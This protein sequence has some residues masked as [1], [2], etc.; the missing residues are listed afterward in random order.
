MYQYFNRDLSWIDF[1][2][3][4]LEEGVRQDAPL[5]ERFKFLSIV[6]SNFDEFF[7]V[8][9]AA[10]KT[11]KSA[12]VPST[13]PSGLEPA[14]ILKKSAEKIRSILHRLYDSLENDLFPVF[15]KAGLELTRLAD[16]SD[17]DAELLESLFVNEI[18]PLLTPLRLEDEPSIESKCVYAAFLLQ[19]ENGKG[20]TVA[21]VK[22][23]PVMER[24]V[25]IP[26]KEKRRFTL[27]EDMV[28]R[29]GRYLYPGFHVKERLLFKINRDAD[30]SVDEKRDE[31]FIEAMTEVIEDRETSTAVCMFFSPDSER[32][33]KKIASFLKLEDEDL[34]EVSGPLQLGDLFQLTN[35]PGF[36]FFKE[37]TWKI[38]PHPAFADPGASIWDVIKASD[39]LIH[40]PYQSFEPVL[41]FFQSA[42]VDPNVLAVKIAL[43]R[44]SG[45]SPIVK[46][47]EQAA[48]NGKQVT[49]FVELKARFDEERNIS[50]ARRL[51][52]AGV[53]VVYG[54]ANLKVHAKAS[55]VMRREKR[56]VERFVHLSTGN[57]NDK[58]A[59][60]YEDLSFFT[61][62]E[63]IAFD[64]GLLFNML[65]GYSVIQPMRRLIIAPTGLKRELLSLIG[66]ES[67]RSS[68][69]YPGR[70]MAKMNA[71]VDTSVIDALYR[72]SQDGVRIDL[73]VRGVCMLVPGVPALSENIRVVSVVDHFLEHSRVFYF[74]NGGTEEVFLSSADWMPRN[75]ERRVELMFPILHEDI[76]RDMV[77]ILEA[78]FKDN[79][80]ARRLKPDGSWERLY[81][82]NGEKPFRVQI[83]LL[84]KAARTAYKPKIHEEFTVRRRMPEE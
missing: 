84:E 14:A 57:Y 56:K 18:Y 29:W 53:I 62:N 21:I 75:L 23:P 33:T 32:L 49:A 45:D 73:N 37:K 70:I 55:L 52:K 60:L 5:L 17:R 59:K 31:D 78:Y 9:I 47:L 24:I 13:D 15:A 39:I 51:E 19:P 81:P 27:V 6:S 61:A 74:A 35:L 38:Y 4:V 11:A 42:A 58:T 26:V 48:L 64:V 66:R 82:S 68:Q 20:E 76:R 67:N 79:C 41:R 12:R 63:E 25:W 3:R 46:A 83:K 43:Y 36:D 44:T 10:L 40:L 28:L 34:Y 71:L 77:S 80:Q 1:N 65:T 50:W 69:E 72:A 2:E 8:R 7:M 16:Y 30:F 54:I 22:I